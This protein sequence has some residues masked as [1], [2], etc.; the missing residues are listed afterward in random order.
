[1][2]INQFNS[3]APY[4]DFLSR[5]VFGKKILES[6]IHF[7][8]K[9]KKN[10]NILILGGGTGHLLSYFPKGSQI[11]YLEK[12][13]KMIQYAEKRKRGLSIRFLHFDFLRFKSDHRYTVVI[14]PF[15]LDCFRLKNL[16]LAI[17]KIKS[18]LQ[19]HGLLI[20][21]DFEKSQT[22]KPLSF[23]MHLFF[24][25]FV[26]LESKNLKSIHLIIS[27]EGFRVT[28]EKFFYRK[29]IFSRVYR[30]L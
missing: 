13:E 7:I 1:M 5:L 3:I 6:Q 23:F 12:S 14:C 9:I 28:D 15:F 30:N 27:K 19:P 22:N 18:L 16:N 2:G 29:M 20:V 8:K 11:D 25:L 17:E 26:N 21:T 24:K 10:D 4:Y